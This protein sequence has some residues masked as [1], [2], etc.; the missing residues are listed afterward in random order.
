MVELA[1]RRYQVGFAKAEL[2]GLFSGDLPGAL[3]EAWVPGTTAT[4]Y[5]RRWHLTRVVDDQNGLMF[6]RIGFVNDSEVSTLRYDLDQQD[7][8]HG[9]APSGIVIPFVIRGTDGLIAYQL[10]AGV[11]RE[12][13]FTGALEDLFNT[14]PTVYRFRVSAVSEPVDY[15]SWVDGVAAVTSFDFT[16]LR[17]NPHYHGDQFVEDLIE[18]VRLETVRLVGKARDGDAIE[19]QTT[20]F[21]QAID[22]ALRDYGKVKLTGRDGDGHESVWVKAK[23]G[24]GSL[25]SKR[26][27][28]G[29]GDEEVPLNVLADVL[30]QGP[31]ALDLVDMNEQDDG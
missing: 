20:I 17:P 5:G 24:N 22:H 8:V 23:G 14:P 2:D 1:E 31:E 29:F 4:R 21:Q 3:Q 28:N 27:V 9:E 16:L 30:A 19:T 12:K 26:I 6:G 7:F 18:D 25:L 10:R 13:T 15:R 11:V